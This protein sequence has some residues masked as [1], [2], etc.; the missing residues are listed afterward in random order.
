MSFIYIENRIGERTHP[1]GA[2]VFI[3]ISSDSTG[4]LHRG[5]FSLTRFGRS[6]RKCLIHRIRAG[7]TSRFNNFL[8]RTLVCRVLNADEKSMNRTRAVDPEVSR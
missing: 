6:H 2:P 1:C 7:L 8:I 5:L 4:S 3:T